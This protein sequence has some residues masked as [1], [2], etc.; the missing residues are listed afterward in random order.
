MRGSRSLQA[1]GLGDDQYLAAEGIRDIGPAF[2]ACH[3]NPRTYDGRDHLY[4]RLPEIK[5]FDM[6]AS[7]V[8]SQSYIR[9]VDADR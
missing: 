1:I 2:L 7:R 9:P 4:G 5:R 8:R 3:N 6:L